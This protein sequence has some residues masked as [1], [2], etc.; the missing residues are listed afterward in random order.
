MTLLERCNKGV[1]KGFGGANNNLLSVL[2]AFC[3]RW[4]MDGGC[5]AIKNEYCNSFP[6]PLC[7]C[8]VALYQLYRPSID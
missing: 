4:K 6:L 1:M 2:C 5:S 3:V 8:T 7:S